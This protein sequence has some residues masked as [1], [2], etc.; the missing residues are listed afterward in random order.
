[1]TSYYKNAV[2][3][4]G[5]FYVKKEDIKEVSLHNRQHK[6]YAPLDIELI[7]REI[8]SKAKEYPHGIIFTEGFHS[9]MAHLLW[10]AMYPT[11]YGLFH[12][13]EDAWNNNF[14]WMATD[15]FY[16]QYSTAWHL[17][18]LETFSGNKLT[19]PN[20]L[21]KYH[22]GPLKIPFL[23]AG[24]ANIGINCVDRSFCVMRSFK[25]HTSDPVETFV[26]RMYKRYNIHRNFYLPTSTIN[27]VYA[28]NKRSYKNVDEVFKQ[29]SEK[30]TD[31]CVFKIINWADYTFKQQLEL[32]NTIGILICGVGTVRGNTPFL[33]NG[34]IEIQTN[35]HS[36]S[37]PNN[38]D[39]FDYHIGT[40]SRFVRVLNIPEYTKSEVEGQLCSHHLSKYIEDALGMLPVKTPVHFTKN[41]P[42]DV[43]DLSLK[44]TDEIFNEWRQTTTL[45]IECVVRKVYSK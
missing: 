8:L 3:L 2:F 23:I 16:S 14:Q 32:L 44:V 24:C 13:D 20:Q 39:Y 7:P 42:T 35:D 29:L 27:I 18:I 33:P 17:D 43:L 37:L 30:Y 9:N 12:S 38:I 26:N 45:S 11:W 15:S 36:S 40:L 28:T 41:I 5:N 1:M 19:A 10:D 31:K 25:D 21:S 6:P 34:S 22:N 4:N